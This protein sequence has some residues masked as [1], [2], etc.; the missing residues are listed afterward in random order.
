MR[1]FL[2]FFF[3]FAISVLQIDVKADENDTRSE[4]SGVPQERAQQV[5][6]AGASTVDKDPV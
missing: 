3:S 5:A 4:K 2:Q 1:Y 6:Q